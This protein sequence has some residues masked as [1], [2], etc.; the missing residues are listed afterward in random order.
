MSETI[1]LILGLT[2]LIISGSISAI[3][4]LESTRERSVKN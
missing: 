3:A 1:I 2:G 4:V